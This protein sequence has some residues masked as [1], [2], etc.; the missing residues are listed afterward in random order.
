MIPSEDR[1]LRPP[2]PTLRSDLRT[3]ESRIVSSVRLR[4]VLEKIKT[5]DKLGFIFNN[6]TIH[7]FRLI[8]PVVFLSICIYR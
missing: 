4:D 7:K 2:S 5:S 8:D 6:L 1:R 3:R